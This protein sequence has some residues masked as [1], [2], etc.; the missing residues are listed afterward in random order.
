M[1]DPVLY[2]PFLVRELRHSFRLG[3]HSFVFKRGG[4]GSRFAQVG[5]NVKIVGSRFRAELRHLRFKLNFLIRNGKFSQMLPRSFC[6]VCFV[7]TLYFV[8]RIRN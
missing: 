5:S 6:S 8:G 4:I 3:S 2:N 7:S 1:R